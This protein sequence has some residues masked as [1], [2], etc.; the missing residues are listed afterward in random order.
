MEVWTRTLAQ[1]ATRSTAGRSHL[2]LIQWSRLYESIHASPRQCR[3][4]QHRPRSGQEATSRLGRCSPLPAARAISEPY[5]NWVDLSAS[6]ASIV[7]VVS[8]TQ[9][10]LI[11][12][13]PAKGVRVLQAHRRSARNPSRD[14]AHGRESKRKWRRETG[15][16]AQPLLPRLAQEE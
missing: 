15:N 10:I 13:G 2:D 16:A 1:S 4:W 11:P 8:M 14:H 7:S 3:Y 9:T 12:E 6:I 5:E